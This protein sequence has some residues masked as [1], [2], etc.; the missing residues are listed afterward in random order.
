M[1]W[2]H[3]TV[4]VLGVGVLFALHKILDSIAVTNSRLLY[5]HRAML[6][7]SFSISNL[8]VVNRS[9]YRG[10]AAQKISYSS[11]GS[12]PNKETK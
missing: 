2:F 4:L 12:Y 5:I 3:A 10:S 9:P 11:T 6:Q 7:I 8:S 1:I